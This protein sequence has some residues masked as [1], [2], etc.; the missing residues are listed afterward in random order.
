M[1]DRPIDVSVL[2]IGIAEAR[3]RGQ[4][5][6]RAIAERGDSS[7]PEELV[8]MLREAIEVVRAAE[9][10]GRLAGA[11]NHPPMLPV[12]AEAKSALAAHTARS[13]FEHEPIRNHGGTT[14]TEEPPAHL[15]DRPSDDGVVVITLVV[16]ARVELTDV[17]DVRDRAE[18]DRAL[19]ALGALEPRDF[20][21][22]EVIG[23]PADE[24]EAV[25]ADRLA[26]KY[27]ELVRLG[28]AA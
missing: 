26:R 23:S 14:T 1:D 11:Q 25:S 16:A 15:V 6:L 28:A 27:P 17:A 7:G 12:E 19:S 18:L 4:G 9:S 24:R 20:V 21:A 3:A 13:R 10:D 2:R 22:M 8:R 5:A